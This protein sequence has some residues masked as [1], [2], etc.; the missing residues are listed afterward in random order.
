MRRVKVL[1][2]GAGPCGLGAALEMM[3]SGPAG[4]R[5]FLLVDPANEAGGW[6]SSRTTA[7]GFT[8]DF[9]G[10]VLFP[11]KH[12]AR[13]GE[14]LRELPIEWAASVPER[15]GAG[16]RVLSAVPGAAQPAAPAAR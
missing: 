9:G 14:L 7:E 3:E 5:D 16:G 13:F 15:G 12:Y 10:H 2:A 4:E 8:F 1:I 6:A 11:H